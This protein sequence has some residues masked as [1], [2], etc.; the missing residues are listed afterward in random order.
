MTEGMK[1]YQTFMAIRL[2]FTGSY[3]YFKYGGKTR[4]IDEAKIVNRRDFHFYRRLERRYKDDELVNYFVSNFVSGNN[5]SWIGDMITPGAESNF[6]KWKMRQESFGY[7]FKQE[8]IG[9]MPIGEFDKK[10]WM[11]HLLVPKDNAHPQLLRSYFAKRVSIE[12]M[13]AMDDVLS[14]TSKW[15]KTMGDDY[16][17]TQLRDTIVKYRPFLKIDRPKIKSTLRNIFLD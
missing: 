7:M 4:K 10:L 2:H 14:F 3:D 8:V 11:D 16:S 6:K 15:N 1:A 5:A 13:I 12:T 17:W 9:M